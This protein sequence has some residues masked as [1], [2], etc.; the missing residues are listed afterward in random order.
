MG[1]GVGA[2]GKRGNSFGSVMEDIKFDKFRISDLRRV[3]RMFCEAFELDCYSDSR[4]VMRHLLDH[5]LCGYLCESDYAI[6]ARSMRGVEGFLLGCASQRRGMYIYRLFKACHRLFLPFSHG[7]RG[8]IRC[9]RLIDDADASLRREASMAD[10]ELQLFVVDKD[11]WGTGIGRSMLLEF[12]KWLMERGAGS[13]QL[14]TD[15]YC[16]VEY[17]RKRGYEQLGV[18]EIEFMPGAASMFYLFSIGVK[19]IGRRSE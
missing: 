11:A 13:M 3:R 6:V 17:Y 19:N 8:Y 5:Y 15:D 9:K 16:D 7:G 2:G 18:R 14:F 4:F 1:V 12:R 10:S